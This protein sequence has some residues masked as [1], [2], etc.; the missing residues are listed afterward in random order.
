MRGTDAV[1]AENCRPDGVALVFQVCRNKVEPAELNSRLNLLPKN[2]LRP[3]DR[4]EPFPNWPEMTL[5]LAAFAPSGCAEGL[6]GAGA[7]PD[8]AFP[9]GEV[10][11]AGPAADA[12]EE[13]ALVVAPEVVC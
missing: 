3:M 1:C 4:D 9:S 8:W 5:V 11:G 10:E 6:A 12:C 2:S 13:V 7:C